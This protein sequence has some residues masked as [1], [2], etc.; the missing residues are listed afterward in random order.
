MVGLNGRNLAS[1]SAPP[2]AYIRR[3]HIDPAVHHE[4]RVRSRNHVFR[5]ANP[6]QILR[7]RRIGRP[8]ANTLIPRAWVDRRGEIIFVMILPQGGV[9]RERIKAV[10]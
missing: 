7:W 1:P 3:G 10:V 8:K 9:C 4:Q 5:H 2:G 6:I